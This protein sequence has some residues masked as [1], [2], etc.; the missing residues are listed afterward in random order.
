MKWLKTFESAFT[1]SE[2]FKLW[3]DDRK[4]I[5]PDETPRIVTMEQ[6]KILENLVQNS[7]QWV[8]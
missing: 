2:K 6:I 5:N 7:V 8:V 3:F 1:E 4:V